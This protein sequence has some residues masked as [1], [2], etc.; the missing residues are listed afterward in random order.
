MKKISSIFFLLGVTLFAASSW[1]EQTK[2]Q[3]FYEWLVDQHQIDPELNT[4]Q[5]IRSEEFKKFLKKNINNKT[6]L[7]LGMTLKNEEKDFTY[8]VQEVLGGPPDKVKFSEDG[9]ILISGCRAQSCPEKGLIWINTKRKEQVFVVLS[10]FYE[11]D[12]FQKNGIAVIYS[13]DFLEQKQLPINFNL[14]LVSWLK[15]QEIENY[16]VEYIN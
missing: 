13:D 5:I 12:V 7:Y 1:G 10:Y 3:D 16:R 6:P 8:H 11:S 15:G 2:N 4:N 14:N 9:I